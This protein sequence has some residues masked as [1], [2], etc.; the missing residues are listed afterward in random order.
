VSYFGIMFSTLDLER[1]ING[2]LTESSSASA[3]VRS[4]KSQG[5]F[6]PQSELDTPGS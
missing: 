2:N 5:I 6:K 1:M 4:Q 3:Y